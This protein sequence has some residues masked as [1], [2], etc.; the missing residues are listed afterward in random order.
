MPCF[1]SVQRTFGEKTLS[2][3]SH[4][5]LNSGFL[6]SGPTQSNFLDTLGGPSWHLYT[7][8]TP[9]K[10]GW[11]VSCD[12][13]NSLEMVEVM[14]FRWRHQGEVVATVS[15]DCSH[16]CQAEPQPRCGNMWAHYHWAKHNGSEVG[17]SM[18]K[19]VCVNC[20]YTNWGCPL[21]V[22]LVDIFVELW[23]VE[24]PVRQR[25]FSYSP[26]GLY[27]QTKGMDGCIESTRGKARLAGYTQWSV[28]NQCKCVLPL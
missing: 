25:N 20:N 21:M 16:Q 8:V 9:R 11:Q 28:N 12:F 2:S 5:F 14:R 23:M 24:Q 7:Q 17:H 22:F 4:W 3:I 15:V 10:A 27:T 26:W 19:G 6:L 13:I 18:L 1:M